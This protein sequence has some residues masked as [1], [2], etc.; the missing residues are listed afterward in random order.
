MS[1]STSDIERLLKEESRK[2]IRRKN[3]VVVRCAHCT[4][5]SFEGTPAEG[6][7]EFMKHQLEEHNIEG[8]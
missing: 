1:L 7:I 6:H 3:I 4:D 5:W 2:T 8:D